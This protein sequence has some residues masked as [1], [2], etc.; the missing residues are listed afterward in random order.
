MLIIVGQSLHLW[1]RASAVKDVSRD[2]AGEVSMD[3]S[4]SVWAEV[5]VDDR[6]EERDKPL[7]L[8]LVNTTLLPLRKVLTL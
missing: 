8:L 2:T 4:S 5:D 3:G 1:L 6:V 7:G